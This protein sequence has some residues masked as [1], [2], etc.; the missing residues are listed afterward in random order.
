MNESEVCCL[1]VW[2]IWIMTFHSV[3]NFIIP[4]DK[5][6]FFRGVQT[7]N[8]FGL[9]LPSRI[10]LGKFISFWLANDDVLHAFVLH[11]LHD[12]GVQRK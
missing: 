3:G 4:A 2:N 11:V 7:T 6:I 10:F 5:V 1:V 12:L 8:Q 9:S